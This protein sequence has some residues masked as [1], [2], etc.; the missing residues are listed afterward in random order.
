MLTPKQLVAATAATATETTTSESASTAVS[1]E[2]TTTTT[3]VAT[4]TTVTTTT[5][6]AACSDW[7]STGWS[8]SSAGVTALNRSRVN[9]C[10]SGSTCVTA[11]NWS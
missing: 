3:E 4:A 1:A 10:R 9:W 8:R 2:S 7:S 11:L 6:S 5:A